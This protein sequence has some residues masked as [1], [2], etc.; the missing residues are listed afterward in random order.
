MTPTLAQVARLAGVSEITASRAVR[1]SGLVSAGTAKRV[2]EAAATI[3]Y[4]QNRVAG[5]LA[6]A[7]SNQ[8]GVILPS[9][10]NI[11]FA[12]VLKGLEDRLEAAGFHPVLGISHYDA[13]REERLV[14]SLLSWRPAGIVV[15]TTQLTPDARRMLRDATCPVIEIMDLVAD[16][17]D[18]TVGISH[19][20]AGRATARHVTARGYRSFAYIGHDISVDRRALARLEGFRRGLAE[21]GHGV[22]TTIL[23]DAASSIALGRDATR[24]LLAVTG[25]P[26]LVYYS[27]DDMAVGG[28]FE[29]MAQGKAV[30]DDIAL[31]GFNGL[32]VGQSLPLPLTTMSSNRALIGATA[33]DLLIRRLAGKACETSVD[34]GVTMMEGATA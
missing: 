6:G 22:A 9:L 14:R 28:A 3:G 33:A 29:C 32:E 26:A 8:V 18:M 12:D 20:D 4:V 25:H 27:N 16:P 10:S 30:P 34:V 17:I 7:A 13:D 5:A 31:V 19:F 11:V 1:G 24:E 2:T 15:A 23:R 21:A